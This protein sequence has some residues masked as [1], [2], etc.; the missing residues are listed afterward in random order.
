VVETPIPVALTIAGHDPLGGAGL[1]ADLAT[2]AALGVHATLAVTALTVQHLDHLDRVDPVDPAMIASQITGICDSFS[3]AAVKAGM[4]GS[5]PVVALI[6][7]RV[8]AGVLPAP[9]V[10]PVL[11][12]GRG[13]RLASSELETA[14]RELLFPLTAVLTPNLAELSVLVGQPVVSIDQVE[15][16]A[17]RI[18]DLGAQATV[19]TGGADRSE[20]AVDVVVYAD[21]SCQR[22]EGVWV[23]TDH[24]RG[25]GCTLAA[26]ITAGLAKGQT[27][28]EA[29]TE[30]KAF[31][32]QR[33]AAS[34]WGELPGAGPVAHWFS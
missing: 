33:L 21:G 31:V 8:A 28:G 12:D 11:V 9:V 19:V 2:F 29:V 26:A 24:V 23:D 6:A 34:R 15:G 1:A 14:Y 7:E 13:N 17:E 5:V 30:A 25:S 3:V 27:I 10:D 18:V 16:I 4:L 22:L 20:H 32:G